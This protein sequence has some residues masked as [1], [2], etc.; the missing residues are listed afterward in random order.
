MINNDEDKALVQ[1][2]LDHLKSWSKQ[3]TCT[4]VHTIG[5]PTSRNKVCRAYFPDGGV[6]PRKQ[7]K[8]T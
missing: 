7:F 1:N 5:S 2:N 4:L 3:T 6:Y 8:R